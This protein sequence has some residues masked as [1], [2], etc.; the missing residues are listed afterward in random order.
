MSKPESSKDNA[1]IR[2]LKSAGRNW[3]VWLA[4]TLTVVVLTIGFEVGHDKHVFDLPAN[5]IGD[6]VAGFGSLLA[7]I[8]L[9]AAVFLQM[10]ELRLQREELKLQ[11]IEAKGLKEANENQAHTLNLQQKTLE[12]SVSV[13][14]RSY[15][16]RRFSETWNEILSL[17]S[18]EKVYF[19]ILQKQFVRPFEQ[20]MIREIGNAD[21]LPQVDFFKTRFSPNGIIIPGKPNYL[22]PN[23]HS[24]EYVYFVM[25]WLE[26]KGWVYS[27]QVLQKLLLLYLEFLSVGEEEF[28]H[29]RFSF[30]PHL[31]NV[32]LFFKYFT[33]YQRS[34][35]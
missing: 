24:D 12:I 6:F 9:V 15:L 14:K 29:E 7:F 18:E 23:L 1:I 8:W 2:S 19:L 17:D 30:E 11:R 31:S 20:K 33:G 25:P 13:E 5:E 35:N 21:A 28:F 16:N 3:V 34:E 4:L 32:S 22:D 27:S 26:V 10:T